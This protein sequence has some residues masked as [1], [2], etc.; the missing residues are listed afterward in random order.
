MIVQVFL[1][2]HSLTLWKSPSLPGVIVLGIVDFVW[3]EKP[4][5]GEGKG[6]LG[7]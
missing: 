6:R 3:G 7:A 1:A 5:K 2:L 4:G